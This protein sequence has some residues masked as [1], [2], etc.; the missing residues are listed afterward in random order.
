MTESCTASVNQI[1]ITVISIWTQKFNI[2]DIQSKIHMD[3]NALI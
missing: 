3:I 1:Y 2:T